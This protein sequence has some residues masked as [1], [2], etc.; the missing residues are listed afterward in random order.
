MIKLTINGKDRDL[1]APTPLVAYLES[2]EVNTRFIAVAH[3]GVVI[4]REEYDDITLAEGDQ[5]EIVRAVGGG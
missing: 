1:E 2:L 4:P 5:V 3:N